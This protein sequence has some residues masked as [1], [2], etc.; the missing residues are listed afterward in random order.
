MGMVRACLVCR[1][2]GLPL[3]TCSALRYFLYALYLR[4][5][6]ARQDH[7]IRDINAGRYAGDTSLVLVTHGLAL[8][9]FLMRW[10][11]W[12]VDQF[13]SVFNPPN[14]EAR[15]RRD[16]PGAPVMP[17][18]ARVALRA[19]GTCPGRCNVL[20]R[21]CESWHAGA[22]CSCGAC[23]SVTHPSAAGIQPAPP[24]GS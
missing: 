22:R 24:L 1:S 2:A 4:T 17:R 21:C 5:A 13:M 9:I 19:R 15:A 7:L 6:A 23:L 12:R 8:R 11:H 10:F 20:F 14:A 3:L 16:A 18:P